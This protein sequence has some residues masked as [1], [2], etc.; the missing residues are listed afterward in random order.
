MLPNDQPRFGDLHDLLREELDTVTHEPF[1]QEWAELLQQ[2][3]HLGEGT[4]DS[5]PDPEADESCRTY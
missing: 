5:Q 4:R 1:P 3:R 2:L